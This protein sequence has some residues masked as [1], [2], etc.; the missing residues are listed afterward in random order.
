[1]PESVQ[2]WLSRNRPPRVQI[3]YDVEIGGAMEK[4]E[5]PLVVG[6]LAD[7]SG[8]P[9][10]A[11]P[12][13]RD[14]RFVEIDRDNFDQILGKINGEGKRT[15]D[16]KEIDVNLG[17]RVKLVV[18]DLLNGGGTLNVDF[19]ID[20]IDDFEPEAIVKKVP[21]LNALLEARKQLRDLLAK[22]DGNDELDKLLEGIVGKTEELEQLKQAAL[23]APSESATAE[24]AA[25]A[26]DKPAN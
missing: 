17:P 7:L 15:E 23:P 24:P 18:P 9:A 10:T 3:T 19:Y 8:T 6:I 13:L 14:R 22:L 5:L 21:Q 4:R 26:E 25:T 1:M 20:G 11:L 16:G 2:H 12:K